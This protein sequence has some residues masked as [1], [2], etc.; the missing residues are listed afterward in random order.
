M[1][2]MLM[3]E[4]LMPSNS[5]FVQVQNA[6]LALS[7]R[8]VCLCVYICTYTHTY[9]YF[10]RCYSYITWFFFI[11]FLR[12]LPHILSGLKEQII[13]I[14]LDK[15]FSH[16]WRL[17]LPLGLI[18]CWLTSESLVVSYFISIFMAPKYIFF[19]SSKQFH[20]RG[21]ICSQVF[22]F[23]VSLCCTWFL[24]NCARSHYFP[25]SFPSL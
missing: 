3:T 13:I 4:I 1:L 7:R 12:F 25:C 21:K 15:H 20:T 9:S 5:N 8:C 17:S 14:P 22:Y 18:P 6:V 19:T 23:F 24:K 16:T 2:F 11:F 10:G